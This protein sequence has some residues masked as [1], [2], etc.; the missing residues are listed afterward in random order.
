M[1]RHSRP[2]AAKAL[3]Q[4]IREK[5]ITQLKRRIDEHTSAASL[6]NDLRALWAAQLAGR[7]AEAEKLLQRCLEQG[8]PAPSEGAARKDPP[9]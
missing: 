3:A 7:E 5:E 2:D 1:L 8:A 4:R 6:A 9:G